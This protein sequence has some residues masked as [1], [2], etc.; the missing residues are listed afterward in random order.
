MFLLI[1]TNGLDTRKCF[2]EGE[3]KSEGLSQSRKID[4][5]SMFK[6]SFLE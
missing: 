2:F 4:K 1:E 3:E 5:R 6:C